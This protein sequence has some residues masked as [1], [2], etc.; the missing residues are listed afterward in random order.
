M[1][2]LR[3]II[4]AAIASGAGPLSAH[5][6]LLNGTR[7]QQN[8]W[9]CGAGDCGLVQPEAFTEARGGW[10]VDGIVVY[11]AGATGNASDGPTRTERVREFWPYRETMPSPDKRAW[12]C[13]RPDGTPRC[14]F[15]G[16]P[17]S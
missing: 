12:R 14:K 7:N 15:K 8:E 4:L 10:V 1:R 11:G 16:M 9:C 2:T 3:V 6:F 17:G 5:E 13:H